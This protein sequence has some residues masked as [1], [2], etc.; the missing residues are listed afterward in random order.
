MEEI[1]FD[2][3]DNFLDFSTEFKNF[4]SVEFLFSI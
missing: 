4:E 2:Y 3:S 1:C